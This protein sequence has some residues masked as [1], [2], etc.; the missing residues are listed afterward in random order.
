MIISLCCHIIGSFVRR[1]LLPKAR[2]DVPC[3]HS[4]GIPGNFQS[5][6]SG[7]TITEM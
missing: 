5:N 7:I 4:L 6:I 2:A 1:R 3:P